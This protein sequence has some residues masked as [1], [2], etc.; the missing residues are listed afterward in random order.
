M[1]FYVL[2]MV[3]C[4]KG[5]LRNMLPRVRPVREYEATR[6]SYAPVRWVARFVVR[7]D[8]VEGPLAVL[9]FSDL[10]GA[11]SYAAIE[12]KGQDI[13]IISA[14][15]EEIQKHAFGGDHNGLCIVDP[16]WTHPPGLPVKV[17]KL[18]E[19]VKTSWETENL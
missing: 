12:H 1:Y 15:D 7:E 11:A 4:Q 5:S 17:S 14:S 9:I 19:W 2:L 10:V 13:A 3:S 16:E 18:A 6:E 8:T